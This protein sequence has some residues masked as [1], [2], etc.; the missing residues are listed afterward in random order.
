M[1]VN[2]FKS[3]NVYGVF[4]N[5]D[6]NDSSNTTLVTAARAEFD[7]TIQTPSLFLRNDYLFSL[8]EYNAHTPSDYQFAN[9]FIDNDIT[10]YSFRARPD[11]ETHVNAVSGQNLLLTVG[12]EQAIRI[13]PNKAVE[14]SEQCDMLTSVSSPNFIPTNTVAV[15]GPESIGWSQVYKLG[16]YVTLSSGTNTWDWTDGTLTFGA[17]DLPDGVYLVNF[18]ASLFSLNGSGDTTTLTAYR[19]TAKHLNAAAFVLQSSDVKETCN[20][21][22]STYGSVALVSKQVTMICSV[23]GGGTVEFEVKT[24]WS[25]TGT[26]VIKVNKGLY[27]DTLVQ[28]V[29]LA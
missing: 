8:T 3:S 12:N 29:R 21:V 6:Q 4:K 13:Y 22:T 1:S 27:Q 2:V 23:Y 20:I 9:S 7:G 14:V 18:Q 28:V 15:S 24:T 10:N 19:I 17:L 25:A 11:G 16:S 26:G 5:K